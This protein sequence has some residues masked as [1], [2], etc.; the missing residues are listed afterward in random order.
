[1]KIETQDEI[2]KRRKKHKRNKQ[3]NLEILDSNEGK[4]KMNFDV[5][6]DIETEGCNNRD[7]K[8]AKLHSTDTD[9]YV[10]VK[11]NALLD[12]RDLPLEDRSE[13]PSVTSNR[14]DLGLIST[15]TSISVDIP[16]ESM[17]N[18]TSAQSSASASA[19]SLAVVLASSS[20]REKELGSVEMIKS[21]NEVTPGNIPS[22]GPLTSATIEI[23]RHPLSYLSA[24][25]Q[26]PVIE[27]L[28]RRLLK[29]QES[30]TTGIKS[31]SLSSILICLE[32]TNSDRR[33]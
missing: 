4:R 25:L 22:L 8:R 6:R 27:A 9:N 19:S 16:T 7:L 12:I 18:V 31:N 29:A 14:E 28:W 30:G 1:M 23:E 5:S 10:E 3:T 15:S 11:D 13:Q 33:T 21:P 24:D 26:A 2:K 17:M 32:D 20:E